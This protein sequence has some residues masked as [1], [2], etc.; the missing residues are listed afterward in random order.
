MFENIGKKIKTYAEFM[1]WVG[2][3]S[4]VIIGFVLMSSNFFVGF[5]VIILGSILSWI[6]SFVLY[7]FGELVDQTSRIADNL[8]GEQYKV[9][10]CEVCGKESDEL[11]QIEVDGEE[12]WVCKN[13]CDDKE[14]GGN[15]E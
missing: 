8:C 10:N 1:T 12:L 7:G 2:I 15:E 3:I 5:L 9:T 13:C 4:S 14:D 11:V 6:S